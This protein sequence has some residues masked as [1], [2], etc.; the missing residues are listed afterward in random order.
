VSA[1]GAAIPSM[2]IVKAITVMEYWVTDLPDGYLIAVS[3]TGYSNDSLALAWLKHFNTMTSKRT[4][5]AWR[6]LLVDGHASHATKEFITY[7][8]D[9]YI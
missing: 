5:G 7:A 9:N 2:V 3:E 4:K 8:L 1:D 6:L